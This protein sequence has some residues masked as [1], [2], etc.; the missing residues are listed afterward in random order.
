MPC[1]TCLAETHIGV[2][3]QP[4][5]LSCLSEYA[6]GPGLFKETLVKTVQTA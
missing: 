1:D 2:S 4:I 3:V 6:L 5:S